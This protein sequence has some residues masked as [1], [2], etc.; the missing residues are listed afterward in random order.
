MRMIDA[1]KYVEHNRSLFF[2]IFLSVATEFIL[3]LFILFKEYSLN[4]RS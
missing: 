1:T 4:P 2:L 3:Y